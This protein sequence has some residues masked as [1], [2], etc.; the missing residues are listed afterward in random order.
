MGDVVSTAEGH[1]GVVV[2]LEGGD[3]VVRFPR[4]SMCR[5]CGACLA[6]GEKQMETRVANA[7]GAAEGDRVCVEIAPRRVAEA[8]VLA[9]LVPLVALLI[10]V[11]IGSRFSDLWAAA[12]GILGSAAAFL[13]LR[14]LEKKRRL[15]AAFAPQMTAV[16]P[17]AADGEDETHGE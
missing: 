2:R 8:S 9:Y 13:L 17:A 11:W 14:A 5:H 3:A 12:G 10:G 16:Y 15:Q 4:S 7:L 1:I 6:I